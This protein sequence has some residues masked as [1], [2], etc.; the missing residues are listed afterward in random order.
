MSEQNPEIFYL[1]ICK[2]KIEKK[3]NWPGSLSWKQRDYNALSELIFEDTKILISLSTLKR[4]WKE[5][6]SGTPHPGTLNAMAHFLGYKNW[7]DFKSNYTKNTVSGSLSAKDAVPASAGKTSETVKNPGKKT[8]FSN[9]R[10][11]MIAL[12]C[13]AA[14]SILFSGFI[15]KLRSPEEYKSVTFTSKKV[16]TRGIPNTVVFNYNISEVN[17]DNVFIQQSWDTRR[18]AKITKDKIF[19]TSVYYYPGFHK[20]KLI[21]DGKIIRQHNINVTTDGW[22]TIARKDLSDLIPVYVPG[23][24]ISDNGI[25]YV[26]P[27]K[28]IESKINVNNNDFYV[29]FYNVMDFGNVY[30]ENFSVEAELKNNLSEGGLTG[31][32]S[33]LIVMCERG[34]MIIP[35]TIPGLIGNIRVQFIELGVSGKENDLSD[36]GCDLSKWNKVNCIVKD[37]NVNIILNGKDIFNSSFNNSAGKIIGLNFLFY[38]CGS[39][40]YIKLYDAAN[41]IA[42]EDDFKRP[43]E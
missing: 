32:Y 26:S 29:S 9:Y 30:G 21:V 31:Q 19:H 5:D 4:I 22:S 38:G 1:N 20:A 16:V 35:L 36:F 13:I 43:S 39:V 3:L 33:H 25:M 37:K 14:V 10:G 18:K 42:F 23:E 27:E 40:N 6:Y 2:D 17:S 41:K 11:L 28:L 24:N 34:R 8:V 15:G 12:I 7:Q